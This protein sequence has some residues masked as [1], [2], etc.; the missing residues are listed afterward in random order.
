MPEVFTIDLDNQVPAV[1]ANLTV[2]R[3]AAY[4]F[5]VTSYNAR[6]TLV[7]SGVWGAYS[8]LRVGLYWG[9]VLLIAGVA[10]YYYHQIKKRREA[11][12]KKAMEGVNNAEDQ[13]TSGLSSSQGPST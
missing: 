3:S 9:V 11:M 1:N 4:I 13:P 12:M 5:L 6:Y 10:T 7:V 2:H 8:V